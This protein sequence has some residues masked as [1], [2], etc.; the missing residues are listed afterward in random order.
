VDRDICRFMH[1]LRRRWPD[2]NNSDPLRLRADQLEFRRHEVYAAYAAFKD[3]VDASSSTTQSA[4]AAANTGLQTIDGAEIDWASWHRPLDA[5]STAPRVD[6]ADFVLAGHSFGGAT[7]FSVLSNAPPSP[8]V[9]SPGRDATYPELPIH[10]AVILDPW[11][12]PIPDPGPLPYPE[13][14]K[15]PRMLV[16]QS[17]GFTLWADH[18]GRLLKAVKQWR[19]GRVLTLGERLWNIV[20]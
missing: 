5:E 16:L 11:L 10:S 20:Y 4:A 7:V 6:C 19:G 12:E 2:K 1:I 3:V 8:S 14:T 9:V 13:K 18:F 17:E 15:T